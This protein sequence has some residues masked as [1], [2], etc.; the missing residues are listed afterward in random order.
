MHLKC[1]YPVLLTDDVATAAAFYVAHFGFAP[2]FTS[3]WYVSLRHTGNPACELAILR[4]DHE[5]IPPPGRGVISRLILNFEVEDATAE[6]QRLQRA[7][8]A[9]IQ[10]LRDEP[11]GQRHFICAG[12]DGVLIDVIEEIPPAPEFAAQFVEAQ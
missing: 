10:P 7:G 8:V 1:F 6:Y 2:T 9:V 5:T 11:F 3:D 4:H 12:P